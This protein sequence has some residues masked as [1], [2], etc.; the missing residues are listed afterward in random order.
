MPHQV[1]KVSATLNL[2]TSVTAIIQQDRATF[3][4]FKQRDLLVGNCFF[5]A[6]LQAACGPRVGWGVD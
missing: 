1:D 5:K 2:F 6:K 4:K 3:H